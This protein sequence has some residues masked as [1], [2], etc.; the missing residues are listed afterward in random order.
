MRKRWTAYGLY[1]LA[2][3]FMISL[4]GCPWGGSTVNPVTVMTPVVITYEGA[5]ISLNTWKA[6]IKGQELGGSLKAPELD[7]RIAEFEKARVA[8]RAA[9][10]FLLKSVSAT[11]EAETKLNLQK[12]NDYLTEVAIE[13]GKA[14]LP[15]TVK[16][17]MTTQMQGGGK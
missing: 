13:I 8:H 11:T 1:L 2:F 5:A 3:I 14:K 6:Y 7:A 16:T 10:D 9:G 17:Q 4:W 15:E 12:Y